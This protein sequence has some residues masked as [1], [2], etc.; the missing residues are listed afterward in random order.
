MECS[1][2]STSYCYSDSVIETRFIGSSRNWLREDRCIYSTNCWIDIETK[3]IKPWNIRL[4]FITYTWARVIDSSSFG[5]CRT[6]TWNKWFII[7]WGIRRLLK[8]AVAFNTVAKYYNSNSG[9]FNWSFNALAG[10]IVG[11]IIFCFRWSW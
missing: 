6:K 2:T 1:D 7:S 8:L 11:F 9:T 4:D 3:I 5:S 10:D